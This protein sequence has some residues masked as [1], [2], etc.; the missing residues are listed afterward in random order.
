VEEQREENMGKGRRGER[1]A[2]WFK[3]LPRNGWLNPNYK[4]QIKMVC[5]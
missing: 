1:A 2:D 5:N 4:L 3:G